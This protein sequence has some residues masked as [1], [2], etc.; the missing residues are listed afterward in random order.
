ML[1]VSS[2]SWRQKRPFQGSISE[3]AVYKYC[4][5]NALQLNA[6]GLTA[7]EISVIE[8]IISNYWALYFQNNIA[9]LVPEQTNMD[10]QSRLNPVKTG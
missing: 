8:H 1:D 2:A 4:R 6:E 5:P 9:C 3:N 10:Q 7:T